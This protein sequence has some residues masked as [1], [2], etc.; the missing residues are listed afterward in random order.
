MSFI[1]VKDFYYALTF[2]S[3]KGTIL[4]ATDNLILKKHAEGKTLL[5]GRRN[6]SCK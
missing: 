4:E 1:A 3:K 2:M 5:S 6:T